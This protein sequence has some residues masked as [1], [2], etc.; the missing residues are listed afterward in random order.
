MTWLL[1]G[2]RKA[3]APDLL[4]LESTC[5]SPK[6]PPNPYSCLVTGTRGFIRTSDTMALFIGKLAVT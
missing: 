3:W 2:S 1:L 6:D 5:K 4:W